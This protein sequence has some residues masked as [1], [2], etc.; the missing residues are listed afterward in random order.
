MCDSSL[1]IRT[2]ARH[3]PE[4][5][6]LTGWEPEESLRGISRP[7]P[8]VQEETG[9]AWVVNG[10]QSGGPLVAELGPCVRTVPQVP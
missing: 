10:L 5:L 9:S 1:P 6:R 3:R 4:D 2:T 7:S 8:Y